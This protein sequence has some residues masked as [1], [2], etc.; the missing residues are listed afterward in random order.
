MPS[1]RYGELRIELDEARAVR[2]GQV[3]EL[4][5]REVE[6]LRYLLQRAGSTVTR[7]QLE[8]EVWG[9][10]AGV[11]SEAVPV[12]IRRLR[13]KIE[14]DPA[15]PEILLTVRGVGWS[16][17]PPPGQARPP[18]PR[19]FGRQAE[20]AWLLE[21]LQRGTPLVTVLGPA[22]V[23]KSRLAAEVVYQ[24]ERPVVRVALAGARDPG[25]L[26]ALVARAL[27]ASE[28]DAELAVLRALQGQGP[29]LLVLDECERAR[30]ALAARW[31][32]WSAAA[33]RLQILATSRLPLGVPAEQRLPL[34][35]LEP[36]DGAQL[37][38]ERARLLDPS[39]QADPAHL[40]T[41]VVALDAL[42]LAIELAA[43]SI[44]LVG[45]EGWLP[46]L[47]QDPLRALQAGE[48]RLEAVLER[49]FQLLSPAD[50]AALTSLSA[51]EGAFDLA[52]AAAMLEV[53]PP[54]ALAR[55][56]ALAEQGLL[57]GSGADFRLFAAVRHR[58]RTELEP[59]SPVWTRHAAWFARLGDPEAVH[60]PSALGERLERAVPDLRAARERTGDPALACRC[61]VALASWLRW[62]GRRE[63]A[64]ALAE[65][66][67]PADVKVT[68]ATIASLAA[69]ESNDLTR[70]I[71]LAEGALPLAAS[72]S[73]IVHGRLRVHLAYVWSSH[74]PDGLRAT[75][76]LAPL[77]PLAAQLGPIEPRYR[78]VE[79]LLE[80]SEE[81]MLQA[82]RLAHR[83]EDT[84]TEAR[85]W[86]FLTD[87]AID[88][89]RWSQAS[90]YAEQ[91]LASARELPRARLKL[92]V[93]LAGLHLRRGEADP[94]ERRLREVESLL[95]STGADPLQVGWMRPLLTA[96]RGQLAEALAELE[97][98]QWQLAR[99]PASGWISRYEEFLRAHRAELLVR[100]G[101]PQRARDLLCEPA[102]RSPRARALLALALAEEG[103][104]DRAEA[105]MLARE[106]L[107]RVEREVQVL[108]LAVRAIV[109][110]LAGRE[111]EREPNAREAAAL[112][113]PLGL[114]ERAALSVWLRRS[115]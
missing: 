41:L 22:G 19:L 101:Q 16:V 1:V 80:Q 81:G 4:A 29:L 85:G 94:A 84:H 68:L 8:R 10:G 26:D 17:R 5:P 92:S 61:A 45:V 107:P 49:S 56:R 21:A 3:H 32:R 113:A 30:D 14:A 52:D 13:Q 47:A 108:C 69:A 36:E 12:C 96:L 58:A 104:L 28:G 91:G 74:A 62:V 111:L 43:A 25:D 38:L 88:D 51:L 33:P 42:P 67:G 114:T 97:E 46:L 27:G 82:V 79:A 73:P 71:A 44:G 54:E 39:F 99:R 57:R 102:P 6:A 75:E 77:R 24:L 34:G 115:G 2:E 86:A 55:L 110:G 83:W 93:G 50:R 72:T 11:V 15:E 7:E 9:F 105:V 63:E 23:G 37:L 87:R 60:G 31:E 53:D 66:D 95:V 65:A 35:P 40:Q 70:A 20:I 64:V 98:H 106:H 90:W 48:T 100:L 76:T 103:E 59:A 112:A 89:G 18:L 109:A 78:L